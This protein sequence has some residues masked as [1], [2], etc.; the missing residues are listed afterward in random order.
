MGGASGSGG[1]AAD[2][3]AN[4]KKKEEDDTPAVS[5]ETLCLAAVE[6]V[7][8]RLSKVGD[9]AARADPDDVVPQLVPRQGEELAAEAGHARADAR[10][11]GNAG[12]Q[13]FVVPLTHRNPPT[14]RV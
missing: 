5:R 9:L 4:Q 12:K 13:N 7:Q 3:A 8:R 11:Q 14:L 2:S 6:I 1:G 10:R